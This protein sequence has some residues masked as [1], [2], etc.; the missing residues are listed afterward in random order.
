M[1]LKSLIK[2]VVLAAV[3]VVVCVPTQSVAALEPA[4][5]QTPQKKPNHSRTRPAKKKSDKTKANEKANQSNKANAGEKSR[6][7]VNTKKAGKANGNKKAANAVNVSDSYRAFKV[8]I[9]YAAAVVQNLA[10]E[11]QTGRAMTV[12]IPV[13]W[14]FSD[15]TNRHGIRTIA[16]QPEARWWPGAN[17]GNGHF[18][19]AHLSAA[20]F[21]VRWNDTR[22]QTAAMPL[23][24]AGVSYGYRLNFTP[25]WGMELNIGAGYAYMKYDRFYNIDNGAK[26]DRRSRHYFGITRLG[27]SIA[28]RF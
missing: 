19:G 24:G 18:L 28:Y 25:N 14:S 9:P 20:C 12:D 2:G 5:G 15:L 26:I 22:Y 1:N 7:A 16:I 8:N 21:N 6:K 27:I 23:L 4:T 10:F 13:M 3:A 11:W 17:P